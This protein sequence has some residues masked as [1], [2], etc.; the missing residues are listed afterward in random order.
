MGTG[1]RCPP[2]VAEAW[3]PRVWGRRRKG[4]DELTPRPP[5][6][7]LV[8]L[9]VDVDGEDSH[10]FSDDEREGAKV[11]RPA[12]GVGI[13]LVVVSFITGVSCIAGD[14]DNDANYVAQT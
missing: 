14:V 13:L 5:A 9:N 11:E 7:L 10:S 3:Y 1:I 8:F 2:A 12:V 6:D 4:T